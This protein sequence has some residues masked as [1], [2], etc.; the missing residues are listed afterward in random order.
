MSN[1]LKIGKNGNFYID[2]NLLTTHDVGDLNEYM[3]QLPGFYV[4]IEPGVTVEEIVHAVFGMKKFVSGYFS[5]D[6]EV[7]RAFSTSSKL[8]KK[9]KAIKFYKSFKV[10]SDDFM[11]DEEFLYVLPEVSFVELAPG[12]TGSEKLGELPIIV[13]E[14]IVLKHNEISLSLKSKFTLLDVLTCVF[15][16]MSSC[17]KSGSIVTV[18]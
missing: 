7:V 8:D 12:E 18:S 15:D 9:Y 3:M 10:E 5:E 6:Y 17:I 11:S 14:N 2:G 4:T 13:D 1:L 16:E